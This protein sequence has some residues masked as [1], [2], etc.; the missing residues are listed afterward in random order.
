M[1]VIIPWDLPTLLLDNDEVE[2]V[3]PASIFLVERFYGQV[4]QAPVGAD[5]VLRL[6]DRS[7]ASAPTPPGSVSLTIEN[8]TKNVAL[9]ET[10]S[11]M[12]LISG[13]STLVVRVITASGAGFAS[14]WVEISLSDS[15]TDLTSLSKLEDFIGDI[16]AANETFASRL[17]TGVSRQIESYCKRKFGSH[18]VTSELHSHGGLTDSLVLRDYPVVSISE[19]KIGGTVQLAATYLL[20]ADDGLLRRRDGDAAIAWPRGTSNI[21]VTY[22]A[23]FATIPADLEQAATIQ[24]AYAYAQSKPGSNRLGLQSTDLQTAESFIVDDWHP[25]VLP[26]LE[27]YVRRAI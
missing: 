20:E 8:G 24:V 26:T 10:T 17:I 19:V 14:G 5:L 9:S 4:Q 3:V 16:P 23:G 13:Q 18:L 6:Q 27:A 7:G 25:Q 21:Q 11:S 22:T 1:G 2:I 12:T 15:I